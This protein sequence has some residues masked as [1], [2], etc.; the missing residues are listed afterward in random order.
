MQCEV[1]TKELINRLF[2]PTNQ[3]DRPTE[4]SSPCPKCH[5]RGGIWRLEQSKLAYYLE[6][7]LWYRCDCEARENSAEKTNQS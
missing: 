5:G 1:L 6:I 2:N 3:L 4:S 7:E